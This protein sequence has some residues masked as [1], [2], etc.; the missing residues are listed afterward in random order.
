MPTIRLGDADRERWGCPEWLEFPAS[1]PV[2]DAKALQAAG[3]KYLDYFNRD[4][5]AGWQVIVWLALHRAGITVKLD[6]LEDLDLAAI[7][8]ADVEPGK[9]PNS[10][11]ESGTTPPTSA[12]SSTSRRRTSK[13]SN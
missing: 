8:I 1:L 6:E 4:E 9:A 11:N 5:P 12:S 2:R 7:S 13:T 3:G 10:D